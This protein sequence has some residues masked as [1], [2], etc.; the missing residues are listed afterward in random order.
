MP[1]LM[2]HLVDPIFPM[3]D[4]AV[5]EPGGFVQ[6]GL[7]VI[8]KWGCITVPGSQHCATVRASPEVQPT[9]WWLSRRGN[10]L[11]ALPIGPSDH[12]VMFLYCPKLSDSQKQVLRFQIRSQ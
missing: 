6:G 1:I 10:S 3:V 4:A 5:G 11:Q 8:S 7:G 2:R 12:K 9:C